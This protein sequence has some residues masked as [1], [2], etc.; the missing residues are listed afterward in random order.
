MRTGQ[1]CHV[2][3]GSASPAPVSGPSVQAIQAQKLAIEVGTETASGKSARAAAVAVHTV[4]QL[5]ALLQIYQ[6][7]YWVLLVTV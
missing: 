3:R 1:F 6:V 5:A 4:Q 2:R 7:S